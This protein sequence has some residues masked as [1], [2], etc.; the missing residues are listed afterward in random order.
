MQ[1]RHLVSNEL[2]AVKK[3]DGKRSTLDASKVNMEADIMKKLQHENIVQFLD[4]F[5]SNYLDPNI[6]IVIE[7]MD[8]SLDRLIDENGALRE[9]KAATIFK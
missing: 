9:K 3:F 8:C 7:L 6:Y 2:V 5:E 1:A 4:I